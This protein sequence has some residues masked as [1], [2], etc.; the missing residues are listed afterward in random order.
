M[1]KKK[2]NR[3]DFE[4]CSEVNSIYKDE[5]E[6][7][8][9][10]KLPGIFFDYRF[11]ILQGRLIKLIKPKDGYRILDAGCGIGWLFFKILEFYPDVNFELVGVDVSYGN[12]K[13]LYIVKKSTNCTKITAAVANAEQLPFKEKSFDA[14]ISVEVLEHINEPQAAIKQFTH[15]LKDGGM[16]M[17]TTPS[18]IMVDF[19][20]L[21]FYVPRKLKRFIER[22]PLV[23]E[24][25]IAYDRPLYVGKLKKILI[26]SNLNIHILERN[27]FLPHE[28]YLPFLPKFIV[29]R[30]INLAKFF[31]KRMRLLVN[32]LGLHVIITC[33]KEKKC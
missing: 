14:V 5:Y 19:W 10:N 20:K 32:M 23:F 30:L 24:P 1:H 33:K 13:K 31:D 27:V 7:S 28:S 29:P 12:I 3:E 15:V 18:K 26:N 8:R 11:P 17:I 2:W 25:L 22:R 16:L 21:V 9:I 4:K 6:L